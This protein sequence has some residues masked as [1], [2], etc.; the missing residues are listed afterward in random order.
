MSF[1]PTVPCQALTYWHGFLPTDSDRF[2]FVIEA[3][4]SNH[5]PISTLV[6]GSNPVHVTFSKKRSQCHLV[7]FILQP[8]LQLQKWS[9]TTFHHVSQTKNVLSFVAIKISFLTH[10]RLKNQFISFNL[11]TP[12]IFVTTKIHE[13]TSNF[14]FKI[15]LG[16]L[17][18]LHN[19]TPF[20]KLDFSKTNFS[21][22]GQI[23]SLLS[24]FY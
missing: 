12:L 11:P 16:F 18:L 17:H 7:S 10:L 6:V 23:F 5:R 4:R 22:M 20:F 13:S 21:T 14:Y 3:Y 1:R 24:P 15:Q 8:Q 19:P 2:A 9:F